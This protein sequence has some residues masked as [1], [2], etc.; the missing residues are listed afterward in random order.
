[1]NRFAHWIAV[2]VCIAAI[3]FS[4]FAQSSSGVFAGLD[5]ALPNVSIR[6]MDRTILGGTLSTTASM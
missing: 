2:L 6:H 1:M 3:A 4:A 5:K